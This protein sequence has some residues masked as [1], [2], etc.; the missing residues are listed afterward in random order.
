MYLTF[1]LRR[2]TIYLANSF[3]KP[4]EKKSSLDGHSTESPVLVRWVDKSLD[5]DG[6]FLG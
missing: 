3:T 1:I 6:L 5:E 2:G 4:Y